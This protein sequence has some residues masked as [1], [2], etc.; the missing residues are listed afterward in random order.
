MA[1]QTFGANREV[2]SQG[3]VM[4][5][6]FLGAFANNCI[7]KHLG[8]L[9]HLSVQSAAG[10]K[11]VLHGSLHGS[12]MAHFVLCHIALQYLSSLFQTLFIKAFVSLFCWS[13]QLL[14]HLRIT[15]WLNAGI[16]CNLSLFCRHYYC[17]LF[18]STKICSYLS[19]VTKILENKACPLFIRL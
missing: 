6:L 12:Q 16:L 13:L 7:G 18:C 5:C 4:P 2:S 17:I 1:L 11:S 3:C 10:V 9:T 19:V 8:K 14:C 15:F